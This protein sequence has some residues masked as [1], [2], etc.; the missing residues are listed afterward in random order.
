VG[1]AE[2]PDA[3]SEGLVAAEAVEA[4][5]SPPGGPAAAAVET[6]ASPSAV[7]EAVAARP[8]A[9]PALAVLAELAWV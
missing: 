5:V 2:K 6:P 9:F 7:P 4:L 1:A 8:A 3:Q